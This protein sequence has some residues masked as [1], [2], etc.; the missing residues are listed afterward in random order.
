MANFNDTIFLDGTDTFILVPLPDTTTAYLDTVPPVIDQIFPSALSTITSDQALSF[1][2]S[3]DSGLS[4]RQIW[5]GFGTDPDD[6]ERVYYGDAFRSRYSSSTLVGSVFT[7]R[8][9]GGWPPNKRIH[10]LIIAVDIRGNLVVIN[11]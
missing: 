1:R 6:F 3:D 9:V 10:L 4:L 11:G 7:V 8:R 5:A 2:L